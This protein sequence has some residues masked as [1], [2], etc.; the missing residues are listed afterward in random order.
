MDS[1]AFVMAE[2][3]RPSDSSLYDSAPRGPYAHDFLVNFKISLLMKSSLFGIR[4]VR[5]KPK[6]LFQEID[7]LLDRRFELEITL[8][9]KSVNFIKKRKS[10]PFSVFVYKQFIGR[11]NNNRV[12]AEKKLLTFLFS[13]HGLSEQF[14]YVDLF[15]ELLNDEFDSVEINCLLLLR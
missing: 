14:E 3:F 5:L 15:H 2:E 7:A 1:K 6:L 11:F 13:V 4:P 9:R 10:M 8:A 12:L